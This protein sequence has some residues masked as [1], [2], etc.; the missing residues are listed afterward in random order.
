MKPPHILLLLQFP[1]TLPAW[2]GSSPRHLSTA[3]AI[4]LSPASRAAA[5]A[6]FLNARRDRIRLAEGISEL[7]HGSTGFKS[8]AKK[9]PSYAVWGIAFAHMT[10]AAP[11]SRS[12]G[13]GG[14]RI[15]LQRAFTAFMSALP[16][17]RGNKMVK[18]QGA[19]KQSSLA[20]VDGM[21]ACHAS[22]NQR[23]GQPRCLALV[24]KMKQPTCAAV[25]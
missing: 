2:E 20:R 18:G 3:F 13:R 8:A 9:S 12:K 22:K 19:L 7:S 17:E 11:V 16:F 6:S 23:T 5:E 10:A 1:Q 24:C 15:T 4:S 14:S 25:S 21:C